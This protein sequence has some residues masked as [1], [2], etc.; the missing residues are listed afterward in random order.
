MK[1]RLLSVLAIV[2]LVVV[3]EGCFLFPVGPD[4]TTSFSPTLAWVQSTRGV[5]MDVY[6]DGDVLSIGDIL[7]NSV[8]KISL[9]RYTPE[10]KLLYSS[11][12][13]EG[14]IREVIVSQ[15][16]AILIDH[17]TSGNKYYSLLDG[18]GGLQYTNAYT[19]YN[20]SAAA[21]D[22]NPDPWSGYQYVVGPTIAKG[23]SVPDST[24]FATFVDR[25]NYFSIWMAGTFTDNFFISQQ[26]GVSPT[27]GKAD[28]FVVRCFKH[29]VPVYLQWG[30]P[31]NDLAYDVA[32]DNIGN[33]TIFLRAGTP[34]P[35][36]SATRTLVNVQTG[37]NIVRLD[38]NGLL[39][40]TF[41]VSLQATG[42]ITDT[43][44]AHGKGGAVYIL[45]KDEVKKQYFL[46]KVSRSGT[47]WIRYLPP[48]VADYNN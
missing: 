19:R 27:F 2:L 21:P 34:F 40:E 46:A 22:I 42:E 23:P 8:Y 3:I 13:S 16:G 24:V 32:S 7:V 10:G 33:A 25:F 11:P 1:T 37:Y 5:V 15:Q 20:T 29:L 41:P 35:I 12:T 43:Q 18:R 47:A 36:T 39:T 45:A 38:T 9:D 31:E 30:G 26:R 4:A 17:P 28:C 14:L 48:A 6:Q 44:I